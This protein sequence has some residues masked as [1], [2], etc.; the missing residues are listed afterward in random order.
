[1]RRSV[2]AATIIALAVLACWYA[3]ASVPNL[4]Y[5]LGIAKPTVITGQTYISESGYYVLTGDVSCA[6]ITGEDACIVFHGH[7]PDFVLDCRGH[8]ITGPGGSGP[9]R[10]FPADGIEIHSSAGG[11][12]KNCVVKDFGLIGILLHHSAYNTIINNTVTNS[13]LGIYNDGCGYN[14]IVNN[15]VANNNYGIYLFLQSSNHVSI[16]NNTADGNEIAGIYL[17]QSPHDNSLSGNT[18]N[19][20]GEYGIWLDPAHNITLAGN[21]ACGNAEAD[22]YCANSTVI[23]GGG[24]VCGH[25]P[26]ACGGT[27]VN[28]VADCH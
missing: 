28:C 12:V 8:S 27:A 7:V 14:D 22:V 13:K 2:F 16:A 23:D 19:N 15:T 21:T 4:A 17:F 6:N 24:N 25:G 3:Y 20:N 9:G 5:D 10:W 1:M 26:A 18:A 11:T